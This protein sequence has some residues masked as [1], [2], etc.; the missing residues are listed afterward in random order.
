MSVEQRELLMAVDHVAGTIDVERDERRL[1]RVAIHPCV[2]QSIGQSNHVAQARSIL[3]GA[4]ASVGNT[5]RADLGTTR[6]RLP[7][8]PR[9]R[10]Q[11]S[12]STT[13]VQAEIDG[14][15][16]SIAATA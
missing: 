7:A 12:D 2:D 10:R 5:D 11:L 1:A 8:K 15:L 3:Q 13:C 6:A 9:R 16:T 14:F 4:T